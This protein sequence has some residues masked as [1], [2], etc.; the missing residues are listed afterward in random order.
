MAS[1]RQ[2]LDQLAAGAPGASADASVVASLAER[3]S[4]A[5]TAMK[6]SN[7]GSAAIAALA[8]RIEAAEQ[9]LAALR[10]RCPR[11]PRH[12]PAAPSRPR[13][14]SAPL[15]GW[16]GGLRSGAPYR[17]EIEAV[18]AF[19]P[20]SPALVALREA[21]DTGTPT[22]DRLAADLSAS[23]SAASAAA[24]PVPVEEGILER[25][26]RSASGLVEVTPLD[27]AAASQLGEIGKR[28]ETA[29]RTGDLAG[30]LR[31]I[32]TLPEASRTALEPVTAAL[33]KRAAL[34]SALAELRASVIITRPSSPG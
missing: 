26:A 25:L 9:A 16:S 13:P 23:A 31:E 8:P 29:I 7:E 11:S 28:I 30:A 33:R 15:T 5:E 10:V 12:K 22:F 17:A 4:A 24:Q 34:E 6:T 14:G 32:A 21:A 19:A 1:L 2:R 18:A 27:G 20:D 3:L